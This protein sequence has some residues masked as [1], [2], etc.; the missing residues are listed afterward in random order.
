MSTPSNPYIFVWSIIAVVVCFEPS[1][2]TLFCQALIIQP[3]PKINVGQPSLEEFDSV[4]LDQKPGI[5][6]PGEMLYIP[7]GASHAATTLTNRSWWPP[8]IEPCN[9]SERLCWFVTRWVIL[10]NKAYYFPLAKTFED[11]TLLFEGIM[12]SILLVWNDRRIQRL[13]R[14]LAANLRLIFYLGRR[15]RM[16]LTNG[17]SP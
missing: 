12:L 3:L 2:L 11:Y 9:R 17:R 7:A 4:Y 13:R 14:L 6:E 10:V 1:R 15:P 5:L 8:M 16:P